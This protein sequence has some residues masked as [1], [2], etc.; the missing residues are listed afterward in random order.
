MSTSNGKI[1][2]GTLIK[3]GDGASP[4][5]FTTIG[6]HFQSSPVG[7]TKPLVDFT[8]HESP[9]T[10]REYKCGVAD[11]DEINASANWV[12]SETGQAAVRTAF[13]AGTP[14]NFQVIS[15]DT[16]ETAAFAAIV[17]HH[18]VDRPLDDR[19]VF[20]FTLKITGNITYT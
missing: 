2:F 13:N 20:N 12:A 17:T 7:A 8:H 19:Q 4:E 6:E 5:V 1:G 16:D 14:Y 10:F 11:G 3:I 9:N 15:P 18:D